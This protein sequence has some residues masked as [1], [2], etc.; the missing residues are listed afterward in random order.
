MTLLADTGTFTGTGQSTGAVVAQDFN[1]SLSGTF[2]ATVQLERS[3]D[4][5][6][7]WLPVTYVD[8]SALTWTVPV[9]TTLNEPELGV[10]YRLNCTAFTSGTVRYRT[11]RSPTAMSAYQIITIASGAVVGTQVWDDPQ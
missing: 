3:F 6:S 1:L 2:V 7:N 9:S 11:S 10:Q 8:G 5:G 4:G